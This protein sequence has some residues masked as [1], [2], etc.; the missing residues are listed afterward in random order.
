VVGED[1]APM[2]ATALASPQPSVLR[3]PRGT[4][5]SLPLELNPGE[6]PLQGARWLRRAEKPRLTLVTLGPV[7]LA[8]LE[9]ARSEPGW[10]VLDARCASPLDEA[11]LL[12]AA[13]CGH[14]VVVE[15]GTT[16]GGLGSAVLELY[17][18][19][20]VTP[21]V[22]LVGMPDVFVPHGDARVQRA[23]LG[24]DVAGLLR[25]GRELLEGGR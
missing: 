18:A 13:A 20:G 7:G 23:E 14:V 10:S 16:R 22:R 4:L 5:P 9:A 1:L 12:E 25:T 17:A 11:A 3:F 15:E 8:A 2:L 24:L 19:R 21:R 6:A